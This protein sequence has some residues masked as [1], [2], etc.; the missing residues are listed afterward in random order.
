MILVPFTWT[1]LNWT[2]L[3]I[4]TLGKK[5]TQLGIMKYIE[6]SHENILTVTL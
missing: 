5:V 4:G 2:I 3:V 6:G 1:F